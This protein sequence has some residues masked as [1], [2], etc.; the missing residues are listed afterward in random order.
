LNFIARSALLGALLLGAACGTEDPPTGND[1][2][3][4]Q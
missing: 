4:R 2:N 1:D 3:D